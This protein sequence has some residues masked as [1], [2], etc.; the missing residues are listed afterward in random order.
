MAKIQLVVTR[1]ITITADGTKIG[2]AELNQLG[3]PVVEL[4][5]GAGIGPKHLDMAALLTEVGDAL[6]GLN[7]VSRPNFWP[8]DWVDPAGVICAP[9]LRTENAYDW[10]AWPVGD[11]CTFSRVEASP[12]TR[13]C[14]AAQ[15]VGEANLTTVRLM[16]WIP[17]AIACAIR[18]EELTFSTQCKN[19]TSET[20]WFRPV[21]YS[22][23]VLDAH[24]SVDLAERGDAISI[25]AGDWLRLVHTFDAGALANLK[26]GFFI[27]WETD[28][29]GDPLKSVQFAQ[30]QL[31]VSSVAS[32]FKRPA[33]PPFPRDD[34]LPA[35]YD[36]TDKATPAYLMLKMDDGQTRRFKPPNPGIIEPVLSWAPA[37][38][39][40]WIANGENKE[41]FDFT[42]GQ[43]IITVPTGIDIMR[44]KAW[45]AGGSNDYGTV[46]GV[47]GHTYASFDVA[48]GMKFSLV[49]GESAYRKATNPY[50]FAGLAHGHQFNGG[51]MGGVFVGEANVAAG[52]F[53]RAILIAGGGGAGRESYGGEKRAGA[54][55]NHPTLSGGM[56]DMQGQNAL[57]HGAYT[58]DGGGGGGYRGGVD[59][60]RA[61][62]GGS[63]FLLSSPL[64]N[65][66]TDVTIR[67]G[68]S[69]AIENAEHGAATTPQ[70][71]PGNTDSD[72]QDPIGK[73]AV[74]VGNPARAAAGGGHAMIVIEWAASA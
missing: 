50:G 16:V 65:G 62:F 57:G 20:A 59:W 63:G 5:E 70:I 26:N 22:A 39:P 72:Y 27:G 1:S 35:F 21:I 37:G 66:G 25:N 38:Y 51:G 14:Y 45:G 12:D 46:G 24:D 67:I 48:A 13:S 23:G 64:D 69:N 33:L 2:A 28:N 15:I 30:A 52:D 43:Q 34:T 54:P 18:S 53:G 42:G 17:A 71:V 3:A 7:F 44:V 60:D 58:G 11:Q 68:D 19:N 47:G 9:D 61:G 40:V 73:A 74:P 56:T 32:T 10:F 4:P 6:R 49:V 36:G 31:E 41:V 8:Q 55:G 29:L